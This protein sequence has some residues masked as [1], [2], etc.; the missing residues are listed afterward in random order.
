MRKLL[1]SAFV[2]LVAAAAAA[3][4]L[5]APA[6][7]TVSTGSIKRA[8]VDAGWTAASLA[9]IVYRPTSCVAPSPPGTGPRPPLTP[10]DPEPPP[11]PA[12]HFSPCAW[13]PY[14]T[15]GTAPC[16][17]PDRWLPN[18]GPGV[19]VVWSGGEREGAGSAPFD[20]P[21]VALAHG[22]AA[23]LL[24]LS[25]IEATAVP[26]ACAAAMGVICPPY[27][28]V[29]RPYELDS[30]V[31]KARP[32][33]LAASPVPPPPGV[34]PPRGEGTKPKRRCR[35]AKQRR[36]GGAAVKGRAAKGSGRKRCRRR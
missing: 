23:Q 22:A 3:L 6:S 18:P 29:G 21:S 13:I 32:A 28:V 31:L 14:A 35:G 16:S 11:E 36:R 30:A 17:S 27:A 4:A 33:F 8:E 15:L 5:A 20:L 24:C 7:A 12:V 10:W 1:C 25:A 26:L 9:G 2:S 34:T 19:Q